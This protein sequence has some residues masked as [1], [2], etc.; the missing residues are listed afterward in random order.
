M[1]AQ[2]A[3]IAAIVLSTCT[4]LGCMFFVPIIFHQISTINEEIRLDVSEF[5]VSYFYYSK[6][7]TVCYYL[8][9]T[10]YFSTPTINWNFLIAM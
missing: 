4:I 10:V 5:N 3:A 9:H 1:S 6:T 8:L 2:V 7:P